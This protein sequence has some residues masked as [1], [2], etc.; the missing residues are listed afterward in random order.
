MDSS[1]AAAHLHG[2]R[3]RRWLTFDQI[4]GKIP[5]WQKLRGEQWPEI[6]LKCY[7]KPSLFMAYWTNTQPKSLLA[8]ALA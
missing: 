5:L 2:S 1:L 7:Q 8:E 3:R 6:Q 4:A